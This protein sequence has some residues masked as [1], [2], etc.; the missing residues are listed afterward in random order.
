[1]GCSHGKTPEQETWYSTNPAWDAKER[2]FIVDALPTEWCAFFNEIGVEVDDLQN[3]AC[4]AEIART[5]CAY[6]S[7]GLPSIPGLVSSHTPDKL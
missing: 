5:I 2:V 4:A 3:P 7:V 1:M 6:G